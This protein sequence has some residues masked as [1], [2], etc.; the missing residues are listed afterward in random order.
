MALM[1]HYQ[2][3]L[4]PTEPGQRCNADALLGQV[5]DPISGGLRLGCSALGACA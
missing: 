2:K 4:D 1:R 5:P 3:D